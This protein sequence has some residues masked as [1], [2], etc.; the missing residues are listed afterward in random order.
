MCVSHTPLYVTESISRFHRCQISLC[1]KI[2]HSPSF[3][4]A[5]RPLI[6]TPVSLKSRITQN[7]RILETRKCKTSFSTTAVG[8]AIWAVGSA[9]SGSKVRRKWGAQPAGH[10]ASPPPPR[11][12][13]RTEQLH[14]A[15]NTQELSKLNLGQDHQITGLLFFLGRI[16]TEIRSQKP[17]M[18][19][20]D[21]KADPCRK[22]SYP[23][24]PF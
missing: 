12:R 13:D 21:N 23:F 10:A 2:T 11:G 3:R 17:P 15:Q 6:N 22:A 9:S 5:E 14:W 19:N 8:S 16:Q 1:L 20:K 7:L 18:R 24:L 4:H